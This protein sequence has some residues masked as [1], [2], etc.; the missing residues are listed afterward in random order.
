MLLACV[1]LIPGLLNK[2]P[3]SALAAVLLFVGYKLTKISLF[4]EYYAKGFDQFVPFVVTILAILFTDLLE[5]ILIGVLVG[6]FFLVRSNFR[7]ALLILNKDDHYLIR[8]R[9][10]VSFLNKAALKRG[11]ESIPE[12]SSLIIDV[13][14]SDFV[15]QD[16]A[17]TVNEFMMHAHLKNIRVAI[18]KTPYKEAHTR[19]MDAP[20]TPPSI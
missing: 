5:G 10:D 8:L 6:V 12:H 17:D 16:I 18:E 19:F 15:D 2:I 14:P 20:V 4:K 7:S 9:K 3:L 1:A 13:T 11:L